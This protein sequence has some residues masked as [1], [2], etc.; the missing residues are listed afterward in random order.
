MGMAEKLN[1]LLAG[2]AGKKTGKPTPEEQKAAEERNKKRRK[3]PHL[4]NK[5]FTDEEIDRWKGEE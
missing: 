3:M 5:V 2:M 1:E 4:G